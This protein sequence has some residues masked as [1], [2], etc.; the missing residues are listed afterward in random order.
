[1][2]NVRFLLFLLFLPLSVMGQEVVEKIEILGNN[3]VTKETVL[4]Y[5]NSR[6][7]DYYSRDLFRSDFKVLWATGF[8]SDIKIEETQGQFGKIIK[9]HVEENS[10][11]KE[12]IYKTG[13][14]VKEDDIVSKLKEKDEYILP[15]SYFNPHKIQ[16]I[17]ETIK[18][19]LI[20]KGLSQAKVESKINARKGNEVEIVFDVNEGP[21][22]RIGEIVFEG[23]PKLRPSALSWALKENKKHNILSWILGKDAFKPNKLSD[24]LTNLKKKFQ[25]HGFMEA[26]IGEP[27]FEDVEKRSIFFR[28]QTMRKI[29]IPVH[30]G[31]RYFVGDITIEGNEFFN[32]K[33]LRSLVTLEKGEVYS[34]KVREKAVQDMQ[35]LYMNYG[36][37]Y[38]QINAVEK[39]DPKNKKVNVT[40]NIYE[41][42]VAYLNRMEFRGNDYTKD[43][44]MRREMLIR[45]GDRF[46]F[47]FFKDS[48][49]RMNQLGLVELDGDPTIN[50]N[51]ADP[52]KIDVTVNVK[53]LQR[54]SI[55]FTGGYSGYQGTFLAISYSTVNLL[56]A[57]EKVDLMFQYGKRIRNYA[58]GFSEPYVFD[59]P[60]NVGFN[61]HDQFM[62]LP[63]LYNRRGKG[64][65]LQFGGRIRG[66]WRSSL[67]YSFEYLEISEY[68]GGEDDPYLDPLYNPY[69]GGYN[70]YYYGGNFGFGKY[71]ISSITPTLYRNTVD[72]PLTPSRG[73][74]YLV[75]CKLAG[76]ILGGDIDMIKPR[77]E[78]TKYLP[79]IKKQSLGLHLEYQFIKSLGD[80]GAPFWERFYLG[81]ER[82]V[83]GYDFYTIGPYSETG[84]NLGGERALVFNAEYIVPVGG[85]LYAIVFYDMGN[86]YA[87]GQKIRIS[88]MFSS[89]GL[90]IRLFVPA[91]RVPFRLI[92][93]YNNRIVRSGDTN[94]RFRFAIG[95]TF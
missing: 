63:G 53:E 39:L 40:F 93:A 80:S 94:F 17:E 91:L 11:I 55:Q 49:L 29:I 10:V 88:D 47:S 86:A 6:E 33:Y 65:D 66:Y 79:I 48:L 46:S 73:T 68:E 38:T 12:I 4:Y 95:T 36:Y 43:K 85:P 32:R 56:G 74:L 60:L 54:N 18:E 24:D 14:K 42:I 9:I 51:P 41:G 34:T 35:E 77:F 59:L 27:R 21:K 19:L 57:G 84:V 25:E 1:M 13:K 8:F 83:R 58:L 7:G 62:I 16:R 75:S 26:V 61:I 72:S 92:F 37:L 45:E 31:Y 3:R 2:K 52:S 67:V 90:E 76:G 70:P 44:V 78:F 20:E 69:Y 50:P 23:N 28:K 30:A 81:G 89:T 5:M 64:L 22:L 82:S 87:P 15:Y 71:N